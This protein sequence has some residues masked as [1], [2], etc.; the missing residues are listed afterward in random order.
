MLYGVVIVLRRAV[1]SFMV[2]T[3]AVR[4]GVPYDYR[5]NRFFERAA[6]TERVSRHP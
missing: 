5:S 4:V 1:L 2:H 3:V 6:E